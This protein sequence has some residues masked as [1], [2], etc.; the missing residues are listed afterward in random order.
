MQS[1]AAQA[2]SQSPTKMVYA[3]RIREACYINLTNQCTLRCAFCPKFNKEWT[4]KGHGLRLHSEPEPA[5][6]LKA[7]GDPRHYQEIVFCGLGESTL[8]LEAMNEIA[9]Q[10]KPSGVCLRLNTDGLAN[11]VYD[12]D[13]TPELGE[14]FDALSVSLNAQSE[15]VYDYHCRPPRPGAFPALLAFVERARKQISEV[16]LTAV[17]GL[18]GVDITACEALAKKLG[19][20]FRGRV[21]DEVG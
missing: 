16:K 4:V 3:Y 8:R 13:I 11:W 6:V 14:R 2:L 18:E 1:Q 5:A 21:L 20:G 15:A 19:V 10:L 17:D 9:D 7:I 12:Q